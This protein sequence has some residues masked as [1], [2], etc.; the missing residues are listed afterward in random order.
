MSELL[1]L[2][3]AGEQAIIA[4]LDGDSPE[5]ISGRVQALWA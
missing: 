1:R 2:R 5:L 3:C 4:Y